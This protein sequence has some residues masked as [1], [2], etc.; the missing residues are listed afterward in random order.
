MHAV[1]YICNNAHYYSSSEIF[2]LS[3]ILSSVIPRNL[4]L[5]L[6]LLDTTVPW[7]FYLIV[8]GGTGFTKGGNYSPVNNVLGGQNSLVKNVRGK[9]SGETSHT[10][11]PERNR[12]TTEYSA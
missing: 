6:Q 8:E 12:T 11:T 3:I 9:L 10:M 4:A 1:Y 7:K 5:F 2:Y